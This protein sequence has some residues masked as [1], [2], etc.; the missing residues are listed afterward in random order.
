MKGGIPER[1]RFFASGDVW[2]LLTAK[3]TAAFAITPVKA[4][5]FMP[6]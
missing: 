2:F 6:K 5:Q 3:Y 4:R 1:L